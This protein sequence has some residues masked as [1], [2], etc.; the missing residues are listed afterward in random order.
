MPSRSLIPTLLFSIAVFSVM[1]STGEDP[2]DGSVPDVAAMERLRAGEVLLENVGTDDSG[3]SVRAQ[4]LVHGDAEKLWHFFASCD[5]TY[6]YVRGLR[7]CRVL[8]VKYETDSDTT[9][10]QQSIKKSWLTPKIDYVISVRRQ[11]PEKVDFQLVEG[12]LKTMDGGWRFIEIENEQGFVLTHEIRLRLSYPAPRWLIRRTMYKD[13]PDMMACLRGL[14][15]GSGKLS[16][17]SDLSRCP[18]PAK[19]P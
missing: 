7:S 9:L 18:G 15:D 16:R 4:I 8:S 11:P 2:I 1:A 10:L 19:K 12:N 3:G 14:V 13:V 5:S 17:D 6:L